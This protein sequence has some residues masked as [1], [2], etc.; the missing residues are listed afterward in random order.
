MLKTRILLFILSAGYLIAALI[1]TAQSLDRR[2]TIVEQQ[3]ENQ[4]STV[5]APTAQRLNALEAQV[6]SRNLQIEGRLVALENSIANFG[7]LLLAV[8]AGVLIQLVTS[9]IGGLRAARFRKGP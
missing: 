6:N 7:Q 8:G 1:V 4:I 5:I 9:A 3:L 2:V